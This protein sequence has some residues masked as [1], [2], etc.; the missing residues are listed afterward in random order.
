MGPPRRTLAGAERDHMLLIFS[1][2]KPISESNNQYTWTTVYEHDGKEYH[3]TSFPGNVEDEVEEM[4]PD[5][6]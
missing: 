1:L 2:K 6:Q 5:D 3:V 4:L